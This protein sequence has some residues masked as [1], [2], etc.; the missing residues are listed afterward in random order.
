MATQLTVPLNVVPENMAPNIFSSGE[1]GTGD[2]IWT[3]NPHLGW[4]FQFGGDQEYYD[5]TD[6]AIFQGITLEQVNDYPYASLP[7]EGP[8]FRE[9]HNTMWDCNAFGNGGMN[10]VILYFENVTNS[11][12]LATWGHVRDHCVAGLVVF[13]R[14]AAHGTV[15]ANGFSAYEFSQNSGTNPYQ[16]NVEKLTANILE[17]LK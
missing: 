2:D 16:G 3:I 4:D 17:Y 9:D 7:L 10:N 8:G 12:V 5:R 1:G 6:H 11:L 15:V 14:N 13:N